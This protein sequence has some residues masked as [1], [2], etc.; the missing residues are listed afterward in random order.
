M[1]GS[2]VL[3]C[4]MDWGVLSCSA[5]VVYTCDSGTGHVALATERGG[6]R[7]PLGPGVGV[8]VVMCVVVIQCVFICC[9]RC[10]LVAMGCSWNLSWLVMYSRACGPAW[11]RQPR[12]TCFTSWMLWRLAHSNIG[13]N[14]NQPD[15]QNSPDT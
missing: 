11:P 13:N 4:E 9:M 14:D 8:G 10:C 1:E 3:L 7:T 12:M 15:G 2:L 5:A 6:E